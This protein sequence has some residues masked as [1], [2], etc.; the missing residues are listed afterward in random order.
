MAWR[1]DGDK[2]RRGY[3]GPS[4]GHV[5]CGG[6]VRGLALGPMGSASYLPASDRA[7]PP[8]RRRVGAF[9][10][11][12][13][14][15]ALVVWLLLTLAPRLTRDPPTESTFELVPLPATTTPAPAVTRAQRE[16]ARAER[17]SAA[18]AARPPAPPVV[19]PPPT[20]TPPVPAE[21][22]FPA[23]LPGL[24]RFDLAGVRGT[25]TPDGNAGSGADSAAAYGPGE[26]PGGERLYNAEWYR[27]PPRSALAAYLPPGGAPPGWAMIACRTVPDY[28][29]E[30]CRILGESPVGS[31][32]ARALRQAA[33]QFR[34]LPPRI[35][36]R[37]IIGAWV[38][39]RFD[40]E[41]GR[42]E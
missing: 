11:A 41:Q 23:L 40:F 1:R 7:S 20:P 38:R 31:G 24:E 14:A 6:R 30:N 4:S 21:T 5:A 22:P 37:P 9:T 27:E 36:G 34:V 29:V 15:H 26:G 25:A 8:L 2:S 33:W 13:A 42:V 12:I 3:K 35:G 39:I 28:R 10:L 17:A 18:P 32:L 19:E 16:R